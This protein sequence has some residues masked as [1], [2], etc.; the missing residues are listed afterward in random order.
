MQQF[1][2]I[3]SQKNPVENEDGELDENES[4]MKPIDIKDR[5]AK[6]HEMMI[7]E[8]KLIDLKS[9]SSIQ[10][11]C[12]PPEKFNSTNFGDDSQRGIDQLS[13]DKDH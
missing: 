2:Q 12:C 3:N 10:G 5:E 4:K 8:E 6:L 11:S 7:M 9:E 1:C 13:V